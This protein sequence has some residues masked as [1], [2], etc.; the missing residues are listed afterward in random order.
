[1]AVTRNRTVD[2]R[3]AA[4]GAGEFLAF[5]LSAG[6]GNPIW[7]FACEHR[8]SILSV[9][10]EPQA[11]YRWYLGDVPDSVED[12][13]RFSLDRNIVGDEDD[14]GVSLTFAQCGT[15]RLQIVQLP[16]NE[17]KTDIAFTSNSAD[18]SFIEPF[19]VICS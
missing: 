19:R 8:N 4:I 6:A 13:P 11:E 16:A 1:M 7:A 9:E 15:Y 5:R 2:K 3:G 18:D 10:D 17:V 12:G 14:Y